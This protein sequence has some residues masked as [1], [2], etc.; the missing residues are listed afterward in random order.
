MNPEAE[1]GDVFF[2]PKQ[3][4]LGPVYN[5]QAVGFLSGMQG[6]GVAYPV[7]KWPQT[8]ARRASF[9][10]NPEY[11]REHGEFWLGSSGT[12]DGVLTVVVIYGRLYWA[13]SYT[14]GRMWGGLG[15]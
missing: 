10:R 3:A 9:H 1:Q 8:N 2:V 11:S 6:T 14:F 12:Q 13:S 15:S 5:I 7:P 4:E